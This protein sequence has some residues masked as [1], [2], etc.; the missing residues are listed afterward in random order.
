MQYRPL[1]K[2]NLQVSA[3][4]LGTMM[5]GDQTGPEEA[6]AIVADARE[7]GVNYIDTADMYSKGGAETLLGAILQG[8]RHDWVLATKLGNRMSARVNEG[9]YS[10][11]WML[12]ELEA[13]L[14]R[15]G[16]DHV[17]ILYLHR[18]YD[19]MDLE[20]PLRALDAMLRD[21][22]IRYWGLSN[23]R[24]WRIAEIMRVAGQLGM[25]GPVVCQPYYNLLNRMPE[26][27][28]LP[29]CRH[30]G[31][32]VTSYSP[33]ARGVLTGKYLPGQAPAEGTR[34]G[35]ADKRMVETEF[36]EESLQIAQQLKA[37]AE[38]RGITLAQFATAWVL[39]HRALSAVIAGPRT[40]AQWQDYLPALDYALTP[41]DE[42]L[43][44]ALVSPGHPSTPGYTDPSYP[45][46]ARGRAERP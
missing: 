1:G 18:D 14:Q 10:R 22:K 46:E 35:R 37:H 33:I 9:H 5:F 6:A 23:F 8:Q 20:E 39:A 4:C 44:D 7:R 17:D 24:G 12:R 19:G 38:V 26:V 42:A 45:L 41:E 29:A 21:G 34:A 3:L 43:V 36:R 16:T 32:G 11:S 2:S 15:L 40:L 31:I 13:S 25:P 28:I 27:E 30:Y